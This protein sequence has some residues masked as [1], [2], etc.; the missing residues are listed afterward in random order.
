MIVDPP[1]EETELHILPMSEKAKGKQR[2]IEDSPSHME[3]EDPLLKPPSPF[4]F[5][6]VQETEMPRPWMTTPCLSI[7]APWIHIT[8]NFPSA[9][10]TVGRV[11]H[12]LISV[13]QLLILRGSIQA[14]GGLAALSDTM[15]DFYYTLMIW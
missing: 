12:Q 5:S 1:C 8:V 15:K 9:Q 4:M 7:P 3:V 10:F 14:C 6:S 2:A 13:L 11:L